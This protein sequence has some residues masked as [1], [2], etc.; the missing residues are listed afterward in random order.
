MRGRRSR[1]MGLAFWKRLII[2]TRSRWKATKPCCASLFT[3]KLNYFTQSISVHFL[4]ILTDEFDR[5]FQKRMKIFFPIP[6]FGVRQV[7]CQ[8]GIGDSLSTSRKL[9]CRVLEENGQDSWPASRDIDLPQ[10]PKQSLTCFPCPYFILCSLM[11]VLFDI[12]FISMDPNFDTLLGVL[13]KHCVV[14]EHPDLTSSIRD[15]PSLPVQKI[16]PRCLYS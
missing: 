8:W 16:T 9:I 11:L 2:N 15:H 10:P 13:H 1:R 14:P 4:I 6:C 12:S 5:F 7:V 3:D